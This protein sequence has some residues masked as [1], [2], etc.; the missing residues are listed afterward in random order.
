MGHFLFGGR[1]IM[2]STFLGSSL[3]RF[4]CSRN[5]R[6]VVSRSIGGDIKRYRL[7]IRAGDICDEDSKA[8]VQPT[9]SQLE[10]PESFQSLIGEE[11][12]NY[13]KE[14]LKKND[15]LDIGTTMTTLSGNLKEKNGIEHI[16]YAASPIWKDGLESELQHLE[17]TIINALTQV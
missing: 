11:G 14:W 15:S 2:R 1:I 16:V 4:V 7:T 5:L 13:C 6:T 8:I 3:F 17:R 10:L 12:V 9:N